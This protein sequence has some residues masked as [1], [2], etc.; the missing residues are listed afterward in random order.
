MTHLT[1][2]CLCG[3]VSFKADGDI[4]F[5]ANCHCRDCQQVTGAAY[6]TLVFMKSDDVDITGALG[7]YSHS[8]DSG[9]TLTKQFCGTCGS[10]M[11]GLNA[12]RPDSIAIR[13]G[14]IDQQA[15]VKPQLNVFASG[16]M[17]CTILDD[18]IPA[19]DKMPTAS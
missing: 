14:Q 6:A 7:S 5:Q 15:E 3:A 19:F 16:K 13:G 8:V 9:N 1:G 4:A 17:D 10:A 12:A 2:Q 11:F 18:S